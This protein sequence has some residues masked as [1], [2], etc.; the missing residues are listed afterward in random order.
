MISDSTAPGCGFSLS[1]A[2]GITLFILLLIISG[3]F[4][5]AAYAAGIASDKQLKKMADEDI[6]GAEF[7]LKHFEK[8]ELIPEKA[9][10]LS[11]LFFVI[12][13]IV[14]SI[15]LYGRSLPE[16]AVG[17]AA[18]A[19]LG[20]V[21]AFQLPK[22]IAYENPEKTVSF[23]IMPVYAV[24]YVFNPFCFL[25]TH[26]TNLLLR[27]FGIA[28]LG[29]DDTV[30]EEEI[31]QMVE[32]G[33]ETGII[34]ETERV[35]IN[36]VFEF[37]D[38]A[39]SR[40]MTHRTDVVAL[41]RDASYEEILKTVSVEGYT[42]IPVYEENLDNIKGILHIK[43]ILSYIK[44]G[45]T[46]FDIDK[47][48][49]KPYFVPQAKLANELFSDMQKNK[50]HMAIVVDEYGGTAGIVTM[51]DLIES[52][53]GNIQD[54][55]D[56]EESK[57]QMVDENTFYIDGA[58]PLNVL[59]DLTD[60]EITED[61]DFDTDTIGGFLINLMDKMPEPGETAVFKNVV[62][63]ITDADDKK[64]NKIKVVKNESCNS[65]S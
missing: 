12:S 31:R 50:L 41:S 7:A 34:P 37:N 43:S 13:L 53:L 3:I 44:D 62:F 60:I 52:I 15:F 20:P 30:T 56:D 54:E 58:E 32:E 51:E 2:Y 61:E 59:C 33:E 18:A 42:R 26:I 11:Q 8:D 55:Y 36:N 6:N 64:I 48:M 9:R 10:Q 14:F 24:M 23:L 16:I 21:A 39:V 57:M 22:K 47:F 29:T 65:E 19:I 35:M 46:N 25:V 49:I 1:P 27:L 45:G 38:T 28:P 63:E 17:I 40:V 5:A 4:Y